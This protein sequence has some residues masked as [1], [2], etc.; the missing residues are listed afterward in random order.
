MR[1]GT[2]ASQAAI[3]DGA[4]AR[5]VWNQALYSVEGWAIPKGNPKA[6]MAMKLI[7]FCANPERQAEYAKHIAYGPTNPNAYKSISKE[8]A[9]ML[10]TNPAYFDKLIYQSHEYWGPNQEKMIERFNAWLLA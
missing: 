6:D 2:A 8:R 7:Q 10:P 3:D 5:I 4:P 1:P 9:A